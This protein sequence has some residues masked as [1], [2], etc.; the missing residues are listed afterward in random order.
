[1]SVV[2]LSS[3]RRTDPIALVLPGTA[4]TGDFVTRAFGPALAAAGFALVTG[5]PPRDSA[6]GALVGACRAQLAAAIRRFRP[7]LLG[8]V[9]L[10]A[11][12][13]ARWLTDHHGGAGTCVG[14]L[15]VAMPGWSGRPD[16]APAAA[17]SRA[18]ADA[19]S[20]HGLAATL[21]DLPGGAPRWVRTE[22]VR[23]WSTYQANE[24]VATLRAAARAEA[25]SLDTLAGI[26]VPTAVLGFADDA[27]HPSSVAKA[28]AAA[29][30][31]SRYT[32]LH[33][34][35][36]DGDLTRLGSAAVAAWEAVAQRATGQ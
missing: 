22:V 30:P 36:V 6:P 10:G 29:I 28:W 24:L 4:S 19:I 2:R 3:G 17:S 20:R 1:M 7:R 21:A 9:S 32:E 23:A 35:D 13:V 12:L 18:A 34:T 26:T 14:G 16:D 8:G 11:H 25:P 31:G 15:I 5:D 27:V 33:L